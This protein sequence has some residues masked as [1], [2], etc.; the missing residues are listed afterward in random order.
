[1]AV[2]LD[3][4]SNSSLPASERA[5][6]LA[7]RLWFSRAGAGLRTA[8]SETA[9]LAA[10]VWCVGCCAEDTDLCPECVT[11]LRRATRLPFRAEAAAS[12]LPLLQDDV[13]EAGFSVMPVYAAAR[14]E[15]VMARAVPAF[16]DRE[17]L[18]LERV[19]APALSHAV[20]EALRRLPAVG[21]Q[22]GGQVLLVPAPPSPHSW[23]RR[24]FDPLERLL[25]TA[26]LS[27]HRIRVL[28]MRKEPTNG[29][30]SL[31]RW[32]AA[33]QKTRGARER[34]SR[35]AG[36]FCAAPAQR[37]PAPEVLLVDDVMTTGAT[38]AEMHRALSAA[39]HQVRGAVVLAAAP[40]P[41]SALCDDFPS[42]GDAAD[43]SS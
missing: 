17:F 18:R 24:G 34:R 32:R 37:N 43:V 16:K 13:S 19:L 8:C 41:S 11:D 26:G 7:D 5:A 42:G 4:V 40:N 30:G 38:L 21:P 1:M 20:A 2:R 35:L 15:H 23:L 28:A 33:G 10:P 29:L 39:G 36:T 9:G 27:E 25:D 12:A 6:L 14:Y 31:L 3:T 22:R